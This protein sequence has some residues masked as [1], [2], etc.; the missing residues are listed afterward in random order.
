MFVEEDVAVR[1]D[2]VVCC[3]LEFLMAGL[4]EVVLEM[5]SSFLEDSLLFVRRRPTLGR[6]CCARL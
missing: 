6:R 1:S 4:E 3:G 2:L 5:E